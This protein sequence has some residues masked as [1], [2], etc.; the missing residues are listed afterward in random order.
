[1]RSAS[2][3]GPT[4]ASVSDARV[5]R[6]LARWRATLAA[7]LLLLP[8]LGVLVGLI[9]PFL[10]GVYWSLTDYKLTSSCREAAS[11]VWRTIRPCSAAR[12][13]G[14][15]V[16]VTLTYVVHRAR[17]RVAARAGGGA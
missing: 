4:A 16:R 7:L 6:S 17:H 3:V 10:I 13:S 15:T 8:A 12:D 5:R 9:V 11:S 14:T 2:N 1:M